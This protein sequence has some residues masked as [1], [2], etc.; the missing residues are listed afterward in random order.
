MGSFSSGRAAE[1]SR[2]ESR[3]GE[4]RGNLSNLGCLERMRG[5]WHMGDQ[6]LRRKSEIWH[7][8]LVTSEGCAD[9]PRFLELPR[10]AKNDIF[11][12]ITNWNR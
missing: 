7:I 12:I 4:P 5:G 9:Q 3:S 11:I 10:F 6:L 1:K 8:S 2:Y